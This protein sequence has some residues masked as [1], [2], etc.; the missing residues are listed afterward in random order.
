SLRPR[1]PDC[2]RSLSTRGVLPWSTWAI[3]AILRR[4]W[5]VMGGV[6][7]NEVR[8][9]VIRPGEVTRFL[10]PRQGPGAAPPASPRTVD[11][12]VGVTLVVEQFGVETAHHSAIAVQ[13]VLARR[14]EGCHF[15]VEIEERDRHNRPVAGLEPMAG[16]LVGVTNIDDHRPRRRD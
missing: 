10:L 5:M 9:I 12:D 14:V 15:P 16:D 8:I 7:R 11:A 6:L 13:Q 1:V 3:M 4:F 2:W